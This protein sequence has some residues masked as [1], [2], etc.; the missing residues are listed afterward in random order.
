VISLSQGVYLYTNTEKRTHTNTTH[1]CTEWD[2]NP[3]SRLPSERGSACL[4]PVGYRDRHIINNIIKRNN[5]GFIYIVYT[6]N[7][8]TKARI[9]ERRSLPQEVTSKTEK[10]LWYTD[11]ELEDQQLSKLKKR[12]WGKK[13]PEKWRWD[14]SRS[15]MCIRYAS[16]S[17]QSSTW[18]SYKMNW[19]GC[20]RKTHR[21]ANSVF[22]NTDFILVV[23]DSLQ[24]GTRNTVPVM[25]HST[26][27]GFSKLEDFIMLSILLT[28]HVTSSVIMLP[29]IPQ[30]HDSNPARGRVSLLRF[31]FP[32]FLR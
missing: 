28:A 11:Q 18:Y 2:S 29:P 13:S 17:G 14:N 21:T 6:K 27:A 12:T 25:F 10:C 7:L 8:A 5:F 9:A 19:S 32:R 24:P 4:R 22:Y 30:V 23:W 16:D 26:E 3:R 1:P 15:I 31:F 20:G